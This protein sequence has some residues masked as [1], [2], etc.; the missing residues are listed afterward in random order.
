MD[1]KDQILNLAC[2]LFA[3]HGY[4]AVGVQQI[5]NDAGV[6]KPTL[7]HHFGNKESLLAAVLSHFLKPYL[8]TLRM[9]ASYEGDI[10]L[11]LKQSLMSVVEFAQHQPSGFALFRFMGQMPSETASAQAIRPYRQQYMA[12]FEALFSAAALDHGN[13]QGKATLYAV[14]F[15][16]MSLTYAALVEANELIMDDHMQHQII[17][18]YLHGV[19][20]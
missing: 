20:S 15:M 6:T 3:Q 9:T 4:D 17:H 2:D 5:V 13:M 12:I 10:Y 8:R 11:T 19:F 7:Y 16:S 1:T 18:S 14:N